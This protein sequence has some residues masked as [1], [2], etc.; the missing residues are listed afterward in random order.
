VAMQ[1]RPSKAVQ[2]VWDQFIKIPGLN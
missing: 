1:R 2:G